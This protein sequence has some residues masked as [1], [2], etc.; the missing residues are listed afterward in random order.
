MQKPGKSGWNIAE[1]L[2]EKG[3]ELLC[4]AL[5]AENSSLKLKL[6]DLENCSRRQ[7]LRII[8][9][10]EGLEWQSPVAFMIFFFT[11]LL[12]DG[13]FERPLEIDSLMALVKNH[14]QMHILGISLSCY[15]ITK[16][17]N[18][19]WK[20]VV[21]GDL[22]NSHRRGDLPLPGHGCCGGEAQRRVF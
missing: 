8:G 21:S 5:K 11:E 18:S 6:D 2:A 1:M 3:N 19:Y 7:N 20:L 17:K 14:R 13:A 9:I 15:T 4:N 22:W 16:P 12:G 10:P